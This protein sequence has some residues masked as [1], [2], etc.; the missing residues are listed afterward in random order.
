MD[1]Q[2]ARGLI[3]KH[4]A[5]AGKDEVAASEI[6]ADD[7]VLEFPQGRERIR[8][9][10]NILAFRSV[11]PASLKFEIRRTIGFAD[12]WVNEYTISYD[13]KPSYVV[14]IMEFSDGLVIRETVYVTDAWEPPEW[15]A[16][17]VEP[18][19]PDP[20]ANEG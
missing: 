8:G 19:D 16:Q 18:M 11:Y 12:L 20:P 13:G 14:G 7:A 9:K 6:Y 5:N 15:R 3:A 2:V 1:E 17:W 4:F 10:A